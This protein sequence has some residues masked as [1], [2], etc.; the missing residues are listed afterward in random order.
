MNGHNI[1]NDCLHCNIKTAISEGTESLAKE[2]TTEHEHYTYAE[3]SSCIVC[4]AQWERSL[5]ELNGFPAEDD[6]CFTPD[7]LKKHDKE[8]AEQIIEDIRFEATEFIK[9]QLRKKY[10]L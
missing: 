8:I 2:E 3:M 7:D 4:K 5:E 1:N 9:D 10:L 6:I